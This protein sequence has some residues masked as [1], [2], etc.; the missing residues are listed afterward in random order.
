MK[1]EKR[2]IPFTTTSEGSVYVANPRDWHEL[3]VSG[4]KWCLILAGLAVS[5]YLAYGIFT[6]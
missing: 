5:G 3:M 4:F 2:P 1:L 6:L